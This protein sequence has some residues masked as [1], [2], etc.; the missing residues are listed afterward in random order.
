[1]GRGHT[2]LHTAA[3]HHDGLARRGVVQSCM[4]DSMDWVIGGNGCG[5]SG[6]ESCWPL[7]LDGCVHLHLWLTWIGWIQ[8]GGE[9]QFD[10]IMALFNLGRSSDC[11]AVIDRWMTLV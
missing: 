9:Q 4:K 8:K 6:G 3:V 1:M 11:D 2:D 7:L 10:S 5:E